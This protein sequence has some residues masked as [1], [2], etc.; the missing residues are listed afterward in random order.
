LVFLELI[1]DLPH[2]DEDIEPRDSI[3]DESMFLISMSDPWYGDILLYIQTQRFHP[4]ISH[5]ER[6]HI[7]HHS[8]CYLIIGDTLYRHGIENI[9]R[10]CCYLPK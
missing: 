7:H 1:S 2:V 8:K 5:E 3:P 4:N 9:L 10:Q 6:R